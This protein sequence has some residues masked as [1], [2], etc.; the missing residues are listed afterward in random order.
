MRLQWTREKV[1]E[2]LHDIMKKIFQQC[3]VTAEKWGKAKN[4]QFGA[5]VA[6][7]LKVANSMLD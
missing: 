1:D 5:N 4:Y 6:G 3:K 7:F 2:E